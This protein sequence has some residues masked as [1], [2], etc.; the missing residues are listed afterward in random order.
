[1]AYLGHRYYDHGCLHPK[2]LDIF[3]EFLRTLE[4]DLHKYARMVLQN[5]AWSLHPLIYNQDVQRFLSIVL[6]PIRH[7]DPKGMENPQPS[8]DT[9]CYAVLVGIL[10]HIN[11]HI[12]VCS[13]ATLPPDTNLDQLHDHSILKALR[14]PDNTPS[15]PSELQEEN[16][17]RE[18]TTHT[19]SSV[20]QD[21]GDD[22]FL[23][24]KS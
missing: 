3:P 7:L 8:T 19:S 12:D 23:V 21:Q 5:L 6:P 18:I 15:L 11:A 9:L 17:R 13:Q 4:G 24:E 16:V 10:R 22:W 2:R 14:A 20:S 1:M